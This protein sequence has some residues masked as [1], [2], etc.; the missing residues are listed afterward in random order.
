VAAKCQLP[1][2][3]YFFSSTPSIAN[4]V[5]SQRPDKRGGGCVRFDESITI[6]VILTEM[7]PH[8]CIDAF[9]STW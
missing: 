3:L 4:I 9:V 7:K 8:Y 6:V 5:R 2:H 1:C